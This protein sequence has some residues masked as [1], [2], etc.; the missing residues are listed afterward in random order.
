M[1]EISL[2]EATQSLRQHGIR[3]VSMIYFLT[4]N[5]VDMIQE[6]QGVI[7][8][9]ARG[10][11]GKNWGVVAADS[12]EQLRSVQASLQEIDHY[13]GIEA[14]MIP[15][16]A[17]GRELVSAELC[18]TYYAPTDLELPSVPPL[19]NLTYEQAPIVDQ[20]WTYQGDWTLP[21]IKACLDQGPSS[22]KM[23]GEDP[24]A[25]AVVQDDGAMGC[26]Y[27]LPD[28][29]RQGYAQEVTYDLVRKVR[30]QSHLPYVHIVQTNQASIKL[31]EGMGFQRLKEIAWVDLR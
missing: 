19:P 3:Y 8:A 11:D 29:R 16:L 12:A 21:Y 14:W 30:E 9:H 20:H 25:W 13:F 27:V 10:E 22:V 17:E 2:Q 4:H 18:Y 6:E 1:R 26:M 5:P 24:V 28:Y 23:I 7:L 15:V 31:T